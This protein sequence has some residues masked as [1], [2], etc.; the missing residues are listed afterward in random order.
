[1]PT[2]TEPIPFATYGDGDA[3][4]DSAPSSTTP[5]PPST[6]SAPQTWH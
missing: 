4:S 5:Q 3:G 2:S 6:P 1:M